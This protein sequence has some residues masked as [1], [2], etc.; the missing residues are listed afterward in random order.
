MLFK[1]IEIHNVAKLYDAERGGT[2][3]LRVPDEVF[4]ALEHGNQA[5]NMAKCCTGVE[6]RFVI[7]SGEGVTIRMAQLD[8]CATGNVFHVFRGGIQGSWYDCELNCTVPGE[9][10]DFFIKKTED[11]P[12]LKKAAQSYCDPWDPEVVRVIFDRGAYRI[13]DVIGDV[14]PP[15]KSMC[16]DKTILFYG[17]SITHGSNSIDMSHAWASVVGHNLGA[18]VINLGFAGSCAMEPAMIDYIAS[19]GKCGQWDTCVMELG[20]NVLGWEKTKKIDRALNA[21]RTVALTNPDKKMFVISPFYCDNDFVGEH[22]AE[23]W[24]EIL[25]KIVKDENLANVKYI[26]GLSLLDSVQYLSADKVHPNIY[27]V[28]KIADGLTAFMRGELKK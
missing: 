10:T 26:N 6:L 27:G 2:T 4:S 21:I 12:Y 28:Q 24:R 25:G 3:W 1:N 13:L 18:D 8:P 7:K 14:M 16:P 23:E 19:L 9:P 5:R 20:I 15:E 11:L 22:K 17:S